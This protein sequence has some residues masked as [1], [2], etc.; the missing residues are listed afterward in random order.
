M[1]SK[2]NLSLVSQKI[3]WK[4]YHK[5]SCVHVTERAERVTQNAGQ[6]WKPCTLSC[7]EEHKQE[8]GKC[9][10]PAKQQAN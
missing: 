9:G 7:F 4:P 2:L 1:K 3:V 8:L 6:E 5:K 10:V